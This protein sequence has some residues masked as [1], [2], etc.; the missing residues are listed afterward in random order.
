MVSLAFQLQDP[1]LLGQVREFLDWTLAHQGAD[2]WIGP[3]SFV[4]NATTPRLVWPRY[5]VLLG[6]IVGSAST[7]S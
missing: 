7:H 5:L 4:A 3:E 1:R 6:L 2:G